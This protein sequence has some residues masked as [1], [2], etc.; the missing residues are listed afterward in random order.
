MVH[1]LGIDVGDDAD[2]RSQ[3]GEGAVGFI[4]LDHHPFALPQ[5]GVGGIG[6]DDAAIDDGGIEA[7]AIE[8]RRHHR[9]RRRLAVRTRDGDGPFETDQ[10]GQHV[11]AAHDRNGPRPRRIDFRVAA[12]D[13]GGDDESA[14]AFDVLGLVADH[15]LR[16]ALGEP[17]R[18]G[19]VLDVRPRDLVAEVQHHFRDAR[20]AD[21]A[22]AHE[23]NR[24]DVEGE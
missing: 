2:G 18:V 1:V 4:R 3:L 20:H 9:R 5:L 15:D 16:S 22:N 6:V 8:Q 24:A 14:D 13:G 23:V 21:A 17:L 11:R 7:D 19:V 12:L 10:L